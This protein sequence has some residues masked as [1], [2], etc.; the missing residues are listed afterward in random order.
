MFGKAEKPSKLDDVE[1]RI[2]AELLTQDPVSADFA[3]AMEHLEKIDEL[4]SKKDRWR[5]SPDTM[6]IVAG[7]LAGILIMVK[8][9]RF[10]VLTSKALGMV[11][12]TQNK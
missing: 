9:E 11:L 8:F 5:V 4:R 3:T 12:R 1:E 7:N 2:F 6:A 10:N